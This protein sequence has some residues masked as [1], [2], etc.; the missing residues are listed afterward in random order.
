M[1]NSILGNVD[2]KA[3][4]TLW[5]KDAKKFIESM[6]STTSLKWT[7]SLKDTKT[8]PHSKT[9]GMNSLISTKGIKSV[10][11]NLHKENSR[12]TWLH[13]QILPNI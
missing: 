11:K 6:N 5:G 3:K 2:F 9:D 12:P 13:W 7:I 4:N 8:K 10:I 1:S